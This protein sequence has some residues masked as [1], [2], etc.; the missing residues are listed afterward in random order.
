M[1]KKKIRIEAPSVE[2]LRD[3]LS[4]VDADLGC[5]PF[6][7][8]TADRFSVTAVAEEA[9]I[10]RMNSRIASDARITG[11][12]R[13]EVLEDVPEPE[14]RLRMVQPRNRYLRGEIPTGLGK[15]E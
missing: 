14:A 4:G 1:P 11:Y 15:K 13:I 5:R 10:G 7:R 9:D 12:V 6:A 2:Y 3:F 8:Q